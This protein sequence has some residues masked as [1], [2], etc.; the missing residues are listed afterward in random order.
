[1]HKLPKEHDTKLVIEG[2]E[3]LS[4]SVKISGAKNAALP[5]IAASLLPTE[6]KTVLKDVPIVKDVIVFREILEKF[7]TQIRFSNNEMVID[8]NNINDRLTSSRKSNEIRASILIAGP[9]LAKYGEVT[10]VDPGGCAIGNRP[11]NFHLKSL[12]LL[13]AK[14]ERKNGGQIEIRSSR[15]RGTNIRLSFPSVGATENLM[16]AASLAEGTT[17]IENAAKEPEI[18]D[19]AHFLVSMGAKIRGAGTSSIKVDGVKKLHATS[20]TLIPDRVEAATYIVASAITGGNVEIKNVLPEHL[21]MP[22]KALRKIGLQIIVN[23]DEKSMVVAGN[24]KLRPL[25]LS[26]APYPGFPTDMQ[27]LLTSLLSTV[28]G[29]SVIV[30]TIFERRLGHVSELN[31]MGANNKVNGNSITINGVEKLHGAN[32]K[33]TDLRAG[34]ALVLAGLAAE[35]KTIVEGVNHIDR[36]Y[37]CLEEKIKKLGAKIHRLNG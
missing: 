32:V 28:R 34:A 30:E 9:L 26:T 22:I 3:K 15:L 8:A 4:G 16:M 21:T 29:K 7:G 1:M 25:S 23:E 36:G 14:V 10:T 33:A 20:H 19:L 13:G 31:R 5:I 17:I 24:K 37:E 18:V 35:G 12:Q 11:I 2:G 6:E 27:P